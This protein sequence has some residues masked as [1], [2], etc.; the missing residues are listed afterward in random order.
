M[1]GVSGNEENENNYIFLGE[2]AYFLALV[3]KMTLFMC[4]VHR[5]SQGGIWKKGIL[6]CGRVSAVK[7]EALK[8]LAWL[9][10]TRQ[11]LSA[12]RLMQQWAGSS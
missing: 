4:N 1:V 10:L 11:R 5:Q 2:L 12:A 6:P 3:V 8:T 9:M 7:D